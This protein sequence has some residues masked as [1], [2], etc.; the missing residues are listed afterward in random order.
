MQRILR[1]RSDRVLAGVC[2]GVAKYF[3]K[4]LL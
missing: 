3:N 1:S 2:G 4:D